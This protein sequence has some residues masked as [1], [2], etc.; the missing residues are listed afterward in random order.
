M[1]E[2]VFHIVALAMLTVGAT[3]WEQR[4]S[5]NTAIK[6]AFMG[7]AA[8]AAVVLASDLVAMGIIQ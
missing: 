3:F 6:F 5:A 4:G 1:V 2:L 7:T 8:G